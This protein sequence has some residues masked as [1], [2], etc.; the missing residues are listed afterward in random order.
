MCSSSVGD[1]VGSSVGHGMGNCVGNGVGNW[2]GNNVVGDGRDRSMICRCRGMVCRGRGMVSRSNCMRHRVGCR[3]VRVD[4]LTGVADLG[5]V[6]VD[7]VGVVV[8]R[9]DPPV[10]KIHRV[11]ALHQTG[12]VVAFLLAEGSLRVVI[13]DSIGVTVRMVASQSRSVICR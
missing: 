7:V 8:H 11:G 13:G 2:V 12:A 4:R 1:W 9:L 3:S 6:A 5:N 10:G